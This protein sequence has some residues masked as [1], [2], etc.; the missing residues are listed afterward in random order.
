MSYEILKKG[1]ATLSKSLGGEESSVEVAL[2]NDITVSSYTAGTSNIQ[3]SN[4]YSENEL[5]LAQSFSESSTFKV[6]DVS[7][8]VVK[9]SSDYDDRE[10]TISICE[11]STGVPGDALTTKTFTLA[12]LA[13]TAGN[14]VFGMD[15]DEITLSGE[16]TLW[17]KIDLPGMPTGEGFVVKGDTAAATSMYKKDGDG[18]WTEVTTTRFHYSIVDFTEDTTIAFSTETET[19]QLLTDDVT[20]DWTA[21]TFNSGVNTELTN[22]TLKSGG[23]VLTEG[24]TGNVVIELYSDNTGAPNASIAVL[25]TIAVADFPADEAN[26]SI[27]GLTQELTASTDYWIVIKAPITQA[28]DSINVKKGVSTDSIS[29]SSDGGANWTPVATTSLV[30][31]IVANLETIVSTYSTGSSDYA[32]AGSVEERSKS[33][34]FLVNSGDARNI[35]GLTLVSAGKTGSP[36]GNMTVE[37]KAEAA[38]EPTGAALASETFA[39]TG[40]PAT[41][42]DIEIEFD[43][44]ADVTVDTDYFIILTTNALDGAT[45]SLKKGTTTDSIISL[46]EGGA[47]SETA[48]TSFNNVVSGKVQMDSTDDNLYITQTSAT[49]KDIKQEY[50][51]YVEQENGSFYIKAK[52]G[53]PENVT[54]GYIIVSE[55]E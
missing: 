54:V 20:A 33:Y 43:S 55:T 35:T 13:E 40:W 12:S 5:S 16:T 26:I 7:L 42:E 46:L 36:T 44:E 14:V 23:A 10:F 48:T 27:T 18:E 49:A 15:D 34:A 52:N 32:A 22:L 38:G 11:D 51:L 41:G 31:A 37:I 21:F 2:T 24:T 17:L 8:N 6:T 53:L 9:S 47:W 30:F 50:P 3:I 39:L 28:G 4:N 29:T 1:T 45:L 19:D 25:D